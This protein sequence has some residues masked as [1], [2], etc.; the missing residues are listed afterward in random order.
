MWGSRR[1]ANPFLPRL[2]VVDVWL[3]PASDVTRFQRRQDISLSTIQAH[4]PRRGRLDD[5]GR[6]IRIEANHG[7]LLADHPVLSRL[8]LR[9]AVPPPL[10]SL[11]FT[12]EIA[13]GLSSPSHLGVAS[14]VSDR[15]RREAHRSGWR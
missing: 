1:A 12:A 9:H 15:W 6:A 3:S 8:Q 2:N 7:D 14:S 10:S 13:P 5:A 11:I 4:H